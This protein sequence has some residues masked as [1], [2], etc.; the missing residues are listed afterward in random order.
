MGDVAAELAGLGVAEQRV[1]VRA[2]DVHLAAVLVHD[3]AEL[4]DGVLVGA[5]RRRVGDH[6]RGQVVGVLLALGAQVVEVD[7]PSSAALTT[8]TRIPAITAEAAL[9]PCAEDGIRQTSRAS[10]PLAAVVA[11]DRQQ[12]GELA[13]R[14]GVRLDRDP[15]VA[16]DLGQPALELADELRGSRRR[17]RPARTGAGRRSRAAMTGSISVVALSFIVQEPSGIMPR[18]SA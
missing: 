14:A 2:V 1:E 3:L 9:V 17:P 10:S 13:L 5:V 4:G 15:V 18:S 12:P 11:A 7:A 6:D 16:G 8:T